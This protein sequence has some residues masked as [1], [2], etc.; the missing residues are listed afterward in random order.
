MT[1]IQSSFISPHLQHSGGI[2]DF[3]KQKADY[4]MWGKVS[5]GVQGLS[6]WCRLWSQL[7]AKLPEKWALGTELPKAEQLPKMLHTFLQF[8]A[9]GGRLLGPEQAMGRWVS[10]SNGSLF[11]MG[12]VGHGSAHVDP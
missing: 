8:H 10:G 11:W 3:E 7:G 9:R 4:R 5:I 1:S 12:H 6:L 2:Q